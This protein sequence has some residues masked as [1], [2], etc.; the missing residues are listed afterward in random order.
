LEKITYPLL[1]Y[2]LTE[3]ASLGI[4]VGT[5][6]QL[7]AAD[8]AKIKQAFTKQLQQQYK[9]HN[10]YPYI[11]IQSPKLKILNISVRP[12][13]RT[14]NS[15]FPLTSSLEIPIPCIYGPTEGGEFEC[16]LPLLDQR[17]VYYE[18]KQFNTLATYIATLYLNRSTPEKLYRYL[19]YQ[20]PTLEIVELKVNLNRTKN[21]NWE[22]NNT[23][24]LKVLPNLAEQFPYSKSIL[25][26]L[27]ATPDIAWELE[28]EV[29]LVVQKIVQQSANI[30][31]V[32]KRGV[33]KSTVLK[34]ATKYLG[35]WQEKCELLV[36]ELKL[37]NG[38]LWVQDIIQLIQTGGQGAYRR[39]IRRKNTNSLTEI[40]RI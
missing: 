40:F 26:K 34:Q 38:I 16:Y 10:D 19:A 6:Y 17:F 22:F 4:L 14:E 3:D 2:E 8:T 37:V 21:F 12:T 25:K 9:K 28:K 15:S 1:C 32:G 27:S 24:N 18:S 5:T 33:G 35:E 13:Y 11:N 20:T 29:D 36:E 39:I 30:L 31:I 23:N 7:V